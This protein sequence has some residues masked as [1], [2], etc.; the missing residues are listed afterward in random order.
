MEINRSDINGIFH[1]N[2]NALN[3]VNPSIIKGKKRCI[4]CGDFLN[5]I[6]SKILKKLKEKAVA[7]KNEMW[8][9]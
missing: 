2:Y 8:E 1:F 3:E 7:I 9:L 6:Y 4:I 5:G